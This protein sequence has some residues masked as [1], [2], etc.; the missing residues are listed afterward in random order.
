MN[1]G[2]HYVGFP[3]WCLILGYAVNHNNYAEKPQLV[4]Q[5]LG[6]CLR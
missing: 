1:G 4:D 5:I 3:A 2:V 6:F